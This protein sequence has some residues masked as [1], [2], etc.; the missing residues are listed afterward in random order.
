MRIND[1]SAQE[2]GLAGLQ[3]NII[4]KNIYRPLIDTTK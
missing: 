2:A 3:P 4:G 1:R